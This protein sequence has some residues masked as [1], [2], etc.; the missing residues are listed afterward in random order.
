MRPSEWGR[1]LGRLLEGRNLRAWA[2]GGLG[3][4][5]VLGGALALFV[6]RG[7]TPQNSP[8]LSASTAAA[9]AGAPPPPPV[10]A[11]APP[12]AT[13]AAA[14]P[15]ATTSPP[16]PPPTPPEGFAVWDVRVV[17][18]TPFS[19]TL[20]WRTTEP[21]R[22]RAA[23]GLAGGGSTLWAPLDETATV[24][25][26]TL[27]GLAYGTAYSVSLTATRDGET[28]AAGLDFQ[29]PPLPASVSA[30]T[31]G[32]AM[33][34]DGQPFFPVMVWGQCPE[35]FDATLALGVNLFAATCGGIDRQFEALAGRAMSAAVFGEREAGGHA[36]VGW[37]YPDEPDLDGTPESMPTLS[38]PPGQVSLLT[39]SNH[40]YSGADPLEHGRAVYPGFVARAD[41]VGFDLYP[42]QE[43]C[44]T[45]RM[46]AVYVSQRELVA[47]AAG[48][49]TFQ[50]IET[51]GM[52]CDYPPF[53]ITPETVRAESWLAIAA[54]ANGLGLF[55]PS[56]APEVAQAV[57]LVTRQI[58]GL[59]PALLSPPAPVSVE[60]DLPVRVGARSFNGA[61]YVIA[62][63]PEGV[64]ARA[65]I[66]LRGLD[67]R[68]LSVL[69]ENRSVESDG[70]AFTDDFAPLAVHVYIAEP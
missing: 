50:W 53:S 22:S 35:R 1:R 17:S 44:K 21:A 16:E 15:A 8:A 39:L 31:G 29:T 32:G 13:T 42:L 67:G 49:P 11:T 34:V 66:R 54:G 57:T 48:K 59:A 7:S 36:L 20:S 23:W 65:T 38:V 6:S 18:L 24:H 12:P 40:F 27:P 9:G 14:P 68:T 60:P 61:L 30:S 3:I 25:Q 5:L 10:T 63:N 70:D 4:A 55:P 51:S 64:P 58:R 2:V 28:T 45:D 43:W 69:D 56:P 26:A 47:L 19:A 46:D 37:F 33:L 52:S 62:V 41:I